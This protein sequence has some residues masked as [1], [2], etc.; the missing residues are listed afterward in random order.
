MRRAPHVVLPLTAS[1]LL[2]AASPSHAQFGVK[3]PPRQ[4][5]SDS[6]APSGTPQFQARISGDVEVGEIA[7]DFELDASDGRHI[8]LSTYRGR[9]LLLVFGDRKETVA[10]MAEVTS[11]LDSSGIAL[12]GVCNEKSYFLASFAKNARF[13]FPILSDVTREISAMYGLDDERERSVQPGFV[14]IEP[15]GNVR[16][17]LLGETLPPNDV[18]R[19]ARYVAT[20][21]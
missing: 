7:P 17:A 20:R 14:M 21:P 10:P 9:W 4:T 5:A 12:L 2:L 15:H 13:P 16:F 1:F 8:Q 6:K 18:A 19:L 11:A 3:E